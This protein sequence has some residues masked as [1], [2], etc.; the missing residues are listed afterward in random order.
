MS[1]R[2]R[3]LEGMS[4]QYNEDK[5]AWEFNRRMFAELIVQDCIDVYNDDGY[6]TDA[7]SDIRVLK[8]FGIL[9]E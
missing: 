9:N 2:L 1:G 4:I 8:H 7:A 3:E 6:Q 5:K